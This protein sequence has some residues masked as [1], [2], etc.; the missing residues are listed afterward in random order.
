MVAEGKVLE[1]VTHFLDNILV[2][3]LKSVVL[4][5]EKQNTD[6]EYLHFKIQKILRFKKHSKYKVFINL[7]VQL[8]I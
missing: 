4:E 2:R 5:S 3:T 1:I 6:P 7:G 8:H